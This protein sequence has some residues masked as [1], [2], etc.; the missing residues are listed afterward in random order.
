MTAVNKQKKVFVWQTC[1]YITLT[2]FREAV[3]R[4]CASIRR[5]YIHRKYTSLTGV[6]PE[7][8]RIKY[9]KLAKIAINGDY[10]VSSALESEIS[11]ARIA[12]G[13]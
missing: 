4:Q 7:E 12:A 1:Y 2:K 13:L 9:G 5:H 8:E 6:V 11:R 3:I 10:S